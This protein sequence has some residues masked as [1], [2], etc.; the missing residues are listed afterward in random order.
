[1]KLKQWITVVLAML[2]GG[3][4][5]V[6]LT[7]RYLN[8][9]LEPS[10]RLPT[11][12]GLVAAPL[13]VTSQP[14]KRGFSRRVPWIGTAESQG[15]VRLMALV[16][17]RV[18][19]IEAKDQMPIQGGVMVAQ[20]GGPQVQTQ[21]D[22]LEASVESLKSQLDLARQTVERLEQSLKVQL[23]TKD[24]VAAAQDAQTKLVTQLSDARLAME[25]FEKRTQIVAPVAGVFTNRR[26]SPGQTVSA[27]DVVGEIIDPDHLRVV[28]SLFP[29]Q[30][31][32]IEGIEATVHLEENQVLSGIVRCVLPQAS[33]T[34]A[35]LIWI[36]GP[37]ID[38]RLHPGQTV[39]G[40][41][42]AEVTPLALAVP[43]SAI[44]YDARERPSVF[45][46]RDGTYERR[47]VQLG[48]TQDGWAEVL[49]G[50]KEGESVVTQGAYELFYR[51]FTQQ[52]KAGD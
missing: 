6:G 40:E 43:D 28:A 4:I 47:S 5:G 10:E 49:S 24:Q 23:A 15:M 38:Q 14:V 48:L 2:T 41:V 18:E 42:V 27:G 52:F 37:Q 26:V 20:L 51:E 19:A 3:A 29:P 25:S 11:K 22:Q 16:A 36:E 34:G 9:N 13:I 17:G 12:P 21:R 33:G 46:R 50:L 35:A 44:V 30:G 31:V 32:A 8:K 7:Y 39:S 1:M 45:V